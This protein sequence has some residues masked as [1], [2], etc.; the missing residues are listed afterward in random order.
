MKIDLDKTLILA[1]VPAELRL[2]AEQTD[3]GQS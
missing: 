2:Q 3:G 1:V